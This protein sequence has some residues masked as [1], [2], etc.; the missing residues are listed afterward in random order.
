MAAGHP[1]HLGWCGSRQ[2]SKVRVSLVEGKERVILALNDQCRRLD[3]RQDLLQAGLVQQRLQLVLRLASLGCGEVAPT[4]SRIESAAQLV[5]I[6]RLFTA[7]GISSSA[8]I[9]EQQ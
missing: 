8:G 1:L 6:L 9:G 4:K 3:C 7:G 2:T 5:L